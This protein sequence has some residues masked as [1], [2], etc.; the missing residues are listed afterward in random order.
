MNYIAVY[1]LMSIVV[2]F[3]VLLIVYSFK[4][5]PEE[6]FDAP[7]INNPD[8]GPEPSPKEDYEVD[9][10]QPVNSN[11]DLIIGSKNKVLIISCYGYGNIGDNMYADVFT[12]Y[13]P[14]CEV[15]K[16]SDHSV[17]VD[18]NKKIVGKPPVNNYP[19]DFLIIGGG[20]LLTATKLRDSQNMPYYINDA[21]KRNKPLFIISCGVQ[22]PIS[23]FKTDFVLWKEVL[24]YAK[25]VTVRS[26]K[27]RE[28]LNSLVSNKVHYFRDLGYVFPHTIRPYRNTSKTITLIIAGP[29]DDRSEVIKKYIKESKKD[30]VIMNMGSLKDDGNNKR[31]IKMNFPGSN[32]IKFYGAGKSPEFT[33]HD[34]F[35]VNQKEMEEILKTNP[36][37]EKVNPSD[38]TLEKVINII[39]NSEIV[40]TGRYHGMIFS[41]SL[42]I[43]Y[44]TLGM[45]TNKVQWEQPIT[46]IR[47]MVLN[48]YNHIKLLR[49]SMGLQDTSAIDIMNLE[50]S[51]KSL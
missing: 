17:F 27:D 44:D 18:S 11:S 29:V 2:I 42:G 34:S 15:V 41:R 31:M 8:L 36:E 1:L 26:T 48:S 16:I 3:L 40:Y 49:K 43:K 7:L 20:G 47:D 46:D 4:K 25:L 24:Q 9:N 19:F 45:D 6:Y 51:I 38:L 33:T 32:V 12:K 14:E 23:N 37:I 5:C 22:G 39:F 28:L 30:V 35:M 13:L 50:G 21:K 10:F